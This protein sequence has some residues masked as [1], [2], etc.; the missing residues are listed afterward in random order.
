LW[1]YIVTIL[2]I[3]W[4]LKCQSKAISYFIYFFL[5]TTFANFQLNSLFVCSHTTTNWCFLKAF[6][7]WIEDFL[8]LY[9]SNANKTLEIWHKLEIYPRKLQNS[10]VF[11]VFFNN[12]E[13]VT[14]KVFGYVFFFNE[15]FN[16]KYYI[17]YGKF[18]SDAH[19]FFLLFAS[20]R[21]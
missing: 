10:S 2:Y 6:I 9:L 8:Y 4:R 12:R 14:E 5:L 20:Y 13:T 1:Y 21:S 17:L 18:K 16:T 11:D 3:G 15:I 19:C 7:F